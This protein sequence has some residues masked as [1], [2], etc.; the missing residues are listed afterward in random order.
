M[1]VIKLINMKKYIYAFC[2]SLAFIPIAFAQTLTSSDFGSVGDQVYL[3]KDQTPGVL[4]GNAGSGQTWNFSTLNTESLDT[5]YFL[6]PS[7][8]PNGSEYP[9]A[10]LAV[11]SDEGIFFFDKSASAIYNL[12]FYL[13]FGPV[14]SN[15]HYTPSVKYLEFPASL[16]TTFSTQSYFSASSYLGVDTNVIS[17]QITIDSAKVIRYT[18][19]TVEFDAS[20]SLQL[21]TAT[22]P[23][24]LRSKNTEI[25]L[26]SI[27]IFAPSAIICPPFINIPAGWSLA[28][29]FLLQLMNPNLS[30]VMQ[31]TS[32]IYN[33]YANNEKF[34]LCAID[35]NYND[36]PIS[37]RFKS[38]ASQIGIG[39]EEQ[40]LIS[41]NIYPN[42]TEG[43]IYIQSESD[44]SQHIFRLMDLQGRVVFATMIQ[45]NQHIQLPVLATGM[46]AYEMITPDHKVVNRGKLN[47]K[48]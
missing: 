17:C 44:L 10:N 1:L 15:V 31:D 33:W 7:S 28:P 32:R 43:L 14:A 5:L 29:D 16:G 4:V 27:F 2:L 26:D 3:G 39:V 48:R 34:S 8:L 46:Y 47:V 9:T 11:A 19:M 22:F 24:V 6:S 13:A 18:D 38:D 23:S 41:L 45:S 21:P 37:A 35:V 20:G 36:A 25:T 12:G 30:G 40:T 42:P